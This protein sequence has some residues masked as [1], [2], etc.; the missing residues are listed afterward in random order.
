M[1][2]KN[3]TSAL[4][5]LFITTFSW[6][7]TIFKSTLPCHPERGY[8]IYGVVESDNLPLPHVAVSD[9]ETITY[10]DSLGRYYLNSSK[11]N[12]HVFVCTP[13]DYTCPSQDAMPQFWAQ[14]TEKKEVAERHDFLLLKASHSQFALLGLTD[15]HLA[16]RYNDQMQFRKNVMPVI[17]KTISNIKKLYGKNI[18]VYTLNTGDSSFDTFWYSDGY[19]I[20]QFPATL[21]EVKYPTP[22][23]CIMGNHDNDG[24][25]PYGPDVDFQAEKRYRATMGP[26]YYSFNIGSVHF[27]MLDNIIY[28]N[29]PGQPIN[30]GIWGKKDYKIGFSDEQMEWIRKDLA[31]Q[32]KNNPLVVCVHSP[33]F[34]RKG[35]NSYRN[36]FSDYSQHQE[37][38][39]LIS[40]FSQTHILSGHTHKCYTFRHDSL[41]IIDHNLSS[42]CGSWWRTA[43]RGHDTFTMVR[44]PDSESL[45]Y[46]GYDQFG[47]DGTPSGF[48]VF[49][50]N[51]KDFS[52]RFQSLSDPADRQFRCFD[53]NEVKKYAQ[54]SEKYDT[55]IKSFPMRYDYRTVP[56]HQVWLN[57]W[58]WEKAWKVEVWENGTPVKV[59]HALLENPQYTFTYDF[60]MSVDKGNLDCKDCK[61]AAHGQS[62]LIQCSSPDSRLTIKVTDSFGHVYT[63]EVKRPLRFSLNQK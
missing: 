34:L 13:G 57:V 47:P 29:H 11:R 3:L 9:G 12:G 4:C 5:L 60:F 22:M 8:N 56:A 45:L 61:K 38:V 36:N 14:L 51:G 58:A 7:Q 18:K 16:N 20:D 28:Q 40:K 50:I 27:L 6:S 10:T 15:I 1:F 43:F 39:S 24:A 17:R 37:F 23:Y 31:L 44:T 42:I 19:T 25:T 2:R 62:F 26:T 63:Q 21:K 41:N 55:F 33:I 46:K 35:L 49:H 52:W 59:K 53:M 48:M 30:V 54:N 32:D